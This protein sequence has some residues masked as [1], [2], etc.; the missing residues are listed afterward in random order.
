MPWPL[1]V[2]GTGWCRRLREGPALGAHVETRE[3]GVLI[4]ILVVLLLLPSPGQPGW[5]REARRALP[6]C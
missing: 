2:V 3:N 5:R 1:V 4:V 6:S